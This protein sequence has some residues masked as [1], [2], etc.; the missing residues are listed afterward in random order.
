MKPMAEIFVIRDSEFEIPQIRKLICNTLLYRRCGL[1]CL[2][3]MLIGPAAPS[4]EK[5]S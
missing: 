1:E 3:F 4:I 5:E 2:F